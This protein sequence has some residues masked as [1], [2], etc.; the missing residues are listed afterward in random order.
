MNKKK[1]NLYLSMA[2]FL[3]LLPCHAFT[4][5]KAPDVHKLEKVSITASRME[6]DT[7]KVAASIDI[8]GEEEM[9][10]FRELIAYRII[11]FFVGLSVFALVIAV[12]RKPGLSEDCQKNGM[13]G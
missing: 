8:A 10:I 6:R 3:S 11:G 2:L 13:V 5:E 7:S 4:D 9:A 1:L 12:G